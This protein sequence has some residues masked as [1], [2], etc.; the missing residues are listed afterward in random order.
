MEDAM[1]TQ[2]KPDSI[3]SDIADELRRRDQP[4]PDAPATV[5]HPGE[6]VTPGDTRPPEDGGVAQ[7]PIHDSDVED[8]GPEDYEEMTDEVEKTGIQD[9]P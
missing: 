1:A 4:T 7:H 6:G 9:E 5:P 8:L 2:R 3:Q